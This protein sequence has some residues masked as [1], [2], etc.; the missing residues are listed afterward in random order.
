MMPC[1]PD[2]LLVPSEWDI[3]LTPELAPLFVIDA[4]I[5]AAQ[6]VFSVVLDPSSSAPGGSKHP[7][8][9]HLLDSLLGLRATIRE[10]RLAQALESSN[11]GD[12][13]LPPQAVT[14]SNPR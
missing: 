10:Y 13:L 3:I 1:V 5:V 4:A 12:G 2:A 8:T 14:H 6:R 7:L 9:S 11:P